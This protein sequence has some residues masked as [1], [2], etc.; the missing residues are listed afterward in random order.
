ML[1]FYGRRLSRNTNSY[2]LENLSNNKF[3]FDEGDSAIVIIGLTIASFTYGGLLG[4]FLL[5]KLNQS[6]QPTSLI[7]G[8]ISSCLIVFFLLLLK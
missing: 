2:E 5:S 3:F 6:F 1:P 8:L 4:L 7:I